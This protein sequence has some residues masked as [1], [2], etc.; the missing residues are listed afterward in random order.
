LNQHGV[1]RQESAAR[2]LFHL[3]ASS[4][5][6]FAYTHNPLTNIL[7]HQ[8]S[9]AIHAWI[10]TSKLCLTSLSYADQLFHGDY[11][12]AY[13]GELL[14]FRSGGY[15]SSS[16]LL[17]QFEA[18]VRQLRLRFLDLQYQSQFPR[19]IPSH[20]DEILPSYALFTLE[21]AVDWLADYLRAQPK[22]YFGY[23]HLLPPHYPYKTRSDFINHFD[24]GWRPIPKP[25][26]YF[27]E[28]HSQGFLD[29]ERRFYDEFIAYVDA[30]FGRLYASLKQR[31]LL[32]NTYLI[33]TSDHG[34]M[35]ERGIY[36]HNTPTL[37]EPV[38]HIPLV[39][40]PPGSKRRSDI[41]ELTNNVDLLPTIAHLA[42]IPVPEWTEGRILPPMDQS[43]SGLR[44]ADRSVFSV[45]ARENPMLSALEKV[46]VAMLTGRHKLVRYLGYGEEV[47]EL[48]DLEQD[49]EELDDLYHP[50]API[51][52]ELRAALLRRFDQ[53][54]H[55]HG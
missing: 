21:A 12:A 42:G 19:G 34:E 26:R 20:H 1:I 55:V 15:P 22:P 27:S 11:H 28:G 35:F 33:F 8:S 38:I 10:K 13:D 6:T 48:F 4:F 18:A 47:Y 5:H 32:E 37:Y 40:W 54:R 53:V 51:A 44:D 17:S 25:P 23:V 30:E 41:Y 29:R 49:P 14:T 50:D 24:D 43:T 2:T 3:L 52:K 36:T 45:E 7:F 39:I 16:V 31:G 9:S 46:T